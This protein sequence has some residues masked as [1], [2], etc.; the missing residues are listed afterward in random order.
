[1]FTD[2]VGYT[3]VMQRDEEEARLVRARH[4]EALERAI[5]AHGGELVQYLGDG[6]LSTFPSVLGAVAAAV[7]VQATLRDAVPLRVGI[8]QGE[9]TDDEQGIYGDSVNIAARVMSLATAGSVLLS[10]KASDELKNHPERRIASLGTFPLKNVARPVGVFAIEG[11]GLTV[12]NRDELLAQTTSSPVYTGVTRHWPWVALVS[13]ALAVVG[14]LVLG[15]A[16]ATVSLQS[17]VFA[18]AAATAFIWFLFDKAEAAMSTQSRDRLSSWLR[19]SDA[20]TL[21][22]SIPAQF[23]VLFDR[24]FGERHLTW[25]CFARSAIA[26]TLMVWIV[27]LLWAVRHPPPSVWG[28]AELLFNMTVVAIVFNLVPDY[29]S[30]LETRYLLS[31]AERSGRIWML[32][33]VDLL[34]TGFLGF[35][36]YLAGYLAF[37]GSPERSWSFVWQLVSFR[38]ILSYDLSGGAVYNLP[39]GFYFYS[40]FFTSA[41]LWLY[42]LSV[43]ASRVL[44]R[45]NQG[46]GFLLRATDVEYQPFRAMGFVSV[47]IAS[48]L[49]ALALPFLLL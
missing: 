3:A 12:P 49:F 36:G 14:G 4:R 41:W 17:Y 30:L 48:L 9:I 2:V 47:S 18:W 32:L 37:G 24:L 43:L 39:L 25:R 33:L 34:A 6:S 38:P 40:T 7:D 19:Q 42:A 22:E 11:G 16:A 8:H 5:A 35:G 46:V 31:R 10:E 15:G 28:A 27:S 29:V 13:M 1:M 23:L 21:I 44:V 26:S 45:M 20:R